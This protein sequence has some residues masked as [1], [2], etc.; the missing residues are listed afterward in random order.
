MALLANSSSIDKARAPR[1]HNEGIVFESDSVSVATNP[2]NTDWLD[3]VY[4]PKG[5]LVFDAILI[6]T[7]IDTNAVPTLF[8][9]LGT[10]EDDDRFFIASAFGSTADATASSN[11][12]IRSN[13][14]TQW[15]EP[16]AKQILRLTVT[17][18]AAT[19]A[20][21]TVRAGV[22]YRLP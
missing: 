9:K 11:R 22:H 1:M 10:D 15:W 16:T 2:V 7:R 3:F 5:V 21:G 8:G 20:A 14:P 19:F 4:I 12:V 18:T 13:Q 6:S 17:A